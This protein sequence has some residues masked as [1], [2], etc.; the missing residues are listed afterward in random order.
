MTPCKEHVVSLSFEHMGCARVH[1]HWGTSQSQ[2]MADREES[3]GSNLGI[4]VVGHKVE[5]QAKTLEVLGRAAASVCSLKNVE[6]W[7]LLL[8]RTAIRRVLLGR[9]SVGEI[10]SFFGAP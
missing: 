8:P 5:G 4:M 9:P 3:R 1:S 7:P 10:V 6:R 2:A